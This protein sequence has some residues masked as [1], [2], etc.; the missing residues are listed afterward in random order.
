MRFPGLF[1]AAACVS[2]ECRRFLI[3]DRRC[4]PERIDDPQ[5]FEVAFSTSPAD[6]V[7][8]DTKQL[9]RL[10]ECERAILGVFEHRRVPDHRLTKILVQA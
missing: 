2:Y 10:S 6:Y 8:G 9:G 1:A 4:K 7:L 5:V 3:H